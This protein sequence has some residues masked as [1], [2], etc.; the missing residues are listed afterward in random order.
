MRFAIGGQTNRCPIRAHSVNHGLRHFAQQADAIFDCAAI[1][2]G[3]Q[4]GVVAQELVNQ[5]AIGCVNLHPVKTCGHRIFGGMDIIRNNAWEFGNIERARFCV[6]LFALW[7]MGQA[8]GR[9]GRR[10]YRLR[11]AQEIRVHKA[12]HVPHLQD[13][14]AAGVMDGFRHWLPSLDLRIRPDAGR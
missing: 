10:R 6:I 9:G 13:D 8:R 12:A 2:V 1:I 14:P 3:T 7:R 4:I 11:A 5:I